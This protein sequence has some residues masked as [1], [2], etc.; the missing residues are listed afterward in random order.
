MECV[1]EDTG[2]RYIKLGTEA[3][4]YEYHKCSDPNNND[5]VNFALI[6]KDFSAVIGG[7]AYTGNLMLRDFYHD[8]RNFGDLTLDLGEVTLKA[9][10]YITLKIILLPWGSQ[11]STDNSNVLNVREDAVLNPYKLTVNTGYEIADT[12]VPKVHV[13]ENGKAE[14][15]I[16]GGTNNAVVRVYGLSDYAKPTIE[17]YVNG[18][19]VAYEDTDVAVGV[20][21]HLHE[22]GALSLALAG[23]A[24]G[25]LARTDVGFLAECAACTHF[26]PPL[27][28]SGL[29]RSSRPCRP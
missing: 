25:S 26:T 1:K 14:F 15:T 28:L 8:N 20:H 21:A 18:A 16:T 19:W 17:E 23:L 3:P 29:R 22:T 27:R 9:G 4:Y 10:D 13:D 12:Y 11:L 5:Y 24:G 7:E 2:N 6:V